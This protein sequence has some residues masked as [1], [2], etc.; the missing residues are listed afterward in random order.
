[1]ADGISRQDLADAMVHGRSASL[2]GSSPE[3][4]AHVTSA[5]GTSDAQWLGQVP[6]LPVL[7]SGLGGFFRATQPG[8]L[9]FVQPQ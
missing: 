1:M 8:K 5:A 3:L 2:H 4:A 9:A 6:E 7:M